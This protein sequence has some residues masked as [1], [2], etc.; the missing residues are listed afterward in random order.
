MKTNLIVNERTSK[1]KIRF[2]GTKYRGGKLHSTC[3]TDIYQA[4]ESSWAKSAA[5]SRKGVDKMRTLNEERIKGTKLKKKGRANKNAK[6]K[7]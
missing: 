7:Y 5:I 1:K 6:T 2:G 3:R 4:R